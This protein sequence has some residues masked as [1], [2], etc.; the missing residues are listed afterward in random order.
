[1]PGSYEPTQRTKVQRLPKR[2]TY[3][4]DVVHS[5]IDQSIL[6]HVG[7][8][9]D[10]VPRVIPTAILR[11]G[12]FVYLHGSNASQLLRSLA[13][14]APACITI[15]IIDS[16]VAARSGFHCAVDYR[17]VVIFGTGEEITDKAEKDAVLDLFVQHMIP[18]HKVRRSKDKELNA[19]TVLRIPLVEVSAKVRDTGAG[20]F[21]EDMDLDLWAGVIPLRTAAGVPVKSPQVADH[22]ETPDYAFNFAGW[23]PVDADRLPQK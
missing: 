1:M 18:G 5:I 8:S 2:G 14:G 21:D 15:C 19:T 11:I 3:D 16:L 20:D 13:A 23:G 9:I 7:V 4:R 17:S 6:C 12:E 10:G 22:I